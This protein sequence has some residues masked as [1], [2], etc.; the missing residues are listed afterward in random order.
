LYVGTGIALLS[1][2]LWLGISPHVFDR[3]G[4]SEG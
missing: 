2:G 4:P 3:I 1:A